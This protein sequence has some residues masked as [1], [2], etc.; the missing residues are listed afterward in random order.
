MIVITGAGGF[1]GTRLIK[2]FNKYYIN[3][4]IAVD[5]F[6][7]KEKYDLIKYCD[8]SE[9]INRDEFLEWFF[10]NGNDIE[11]VYHLGARTDT[12]EMNSEIFN[13]LNLKYSKDIWNLCSIMG[14]PLIY[15]SSAA[16]YGNGEFEYD[17]NEDEIPN[18]KP[19]NFYGQ[20]KQDFD[21]WVLEDVIIKPKYWAGLKFFNVFGY[22]E[23]NKGRMASV[24]FHGINQIKETGKLKLFKSH[25]DDYNDGHQTRDFIWVEDVVRILAD[26]YG[27]METLQPN[28]IY[29]LGTGEGRTFIDLGNVIFNAM[30]L[31]PNIEFINTPIDIRDKYQYYTQANMNKLDLLGVDVR[32]STLEDAVKVYVFQTMNNNSKCPQCNDGWI[33][34]LNYRTVYVC[35]NGHKWNM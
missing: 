5:D 2:Y 11:I 34:R 26:F 33:R 22:G 28:G 12:S 23:Y 7:I 32:C 30:G 20:S 13:K 29:N 35:G 15:A 8:V 14:I 27:N 24:V 17:D 9:L 21:K 25:R 16:T 4:I 10:L 31:E 3:N 19:L 6:D 18:L 1:I